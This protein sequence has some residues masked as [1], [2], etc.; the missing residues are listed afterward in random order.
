MPARKDAP[1]GWRIIA[2]KGPVKVL[3]APARCQARPGS[4]SIKPPPRP[5]DPGVGRHDQPQA[6]GRR[7]G[8]T[9]GRSAEEPAS[10]RTTRRPA[11]SRL[12]SPPAPRAAAR[13]AL[14]CPG[15]AE[16]FH[17]AVSR[18]R[19]RA[20]AG[21]R[22]TPRVGPSQGPGEAGRKPKTSAAVSSLPRGRAEW[23]AGRTAR[24]SEPLPPSLRVPLLSSASVTLSL[25]PVFS[26]VSFP[27]GIQE[28]IEGSSPSLLS[29]SLL[30]APPWCTPGLPE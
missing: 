20:R 17:S 3:R 15:R 11:S 12:Q 19:E 23:G 24:T 7:S 28:I 29:P 9:A 13:P 30:P 26:H 16:D 10:H 18:E 4:L 25:S 1:E 21:L 6:E 14:S 5:S 27:R 22:G 8:D 2:T